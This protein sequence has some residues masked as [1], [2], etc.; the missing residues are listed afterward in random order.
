MIKYIYITIVMI[1]IITIFQFKNVFTCKWSSNIKMKLFP[2]ILTL[3]LGVISISEQGTFKHSEL[4]KEIKE[5][6]ASTI[7]MRNLY[8]H[9]SNYNSIENT[10]S[11]IT[12]ENLDDETNITENN[13][14]QILIVDDSNPMVLDDIRLNPKKYIGRKLEVHGFICKESYL[15]INQFIIGKIVMNCCAADSKVVGIIAEYNKIY[16]LNENE[17][18]NV[19]GIISSSTIKDDNDISHRVPILI[20]EKI[21]ERN[22]Q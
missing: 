4:N 17:N 19:K 1:S 7:D 22:S 14:A 5:G 6:T 8:E 21:D 12:K 10:S 20:I 15:N 13:K 2:I 18:V 11:Q 16:E 3:I 9:K